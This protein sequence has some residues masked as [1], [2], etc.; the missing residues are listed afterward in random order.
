MTTGRFGTPARDLRARSQVP[1]WI[2]LPYT[3]LVAAA[4]VAYTV[5]DRL[6]LLLWFSDM[7]LIGLAV[8]MWLESRLLASMMA[9]VVLLPELGWTAAFVTA[10]IGGEAPLGQ[11][12]YMLDPSYPL[13]LRVISLHHLLLPWIALW[14]VA[15]LGY[16]RRALPLQTLWGW[17]L[18]LLAWLLT[19]PQHNINRV[20][21]PTPEP[22]TALSPVAYLALIMIAMPLA[23]YLPT[24][25][26]LVRLFGGKRDADRG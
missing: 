18:M 4:L 16:S 25:L 14:L 22:Q 3:V 2:R 11:V 24:H 5:T 1:S 26:L 13:P 21:G 6:V 15:R 12:G 8:A 23:I 10:L 9:L 7:A 20:F 19:D 17:V